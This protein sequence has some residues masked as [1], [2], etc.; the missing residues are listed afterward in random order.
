MSPA[1][2]SQMMTKLSSLI[3]RDSGT[4]SVLL[5]KK[6]WATRDARR[7]AERLWA[8]SE[9]KI[10]TLLRTPANFLSVLSDF[11]GSCSVVAFDVA[12]ENVEGVERHLV[13]KGADAQ[14]DFGEELGDEG[15]MSMPPRPA[16]CV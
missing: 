16:P 12:D 1:F 11:K 13:P 8:C 3:S 15:L 6:P 5:L 2:G 4:G 14:L 9:A 7:V 10:K